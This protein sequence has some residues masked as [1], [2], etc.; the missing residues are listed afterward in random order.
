DALPISNNVEPICV[1]GTAQHLILFRRKIDRDQSVE[2]YR[3]CI[4]R[5][6]L[7]AVGMKGIEITHQDNRR[8]LVHLAKAPRQIENAIDGHSSIERTQRGCLDR[9]AVRHGIRERNAQFDKVRAGGRKPLENAKGSFPIRIACSDKRNE[10][11]AAGALQ[12]RESPRDAA[13]IVA[14]SAL[15]AVNT[16][17]SPRPESVTIMTR[18]FAIFGAMRI[19]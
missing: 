16:S 17:L 1:G 6:T 11:R 13:H 5:E 15:A 7:D 10:G 8:V 3:C 2:A 12:L 19:T 18:S 14:P 9:W 4:A